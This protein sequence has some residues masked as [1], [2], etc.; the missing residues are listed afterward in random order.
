M[1]LEDY[2]RK[3]VFFVNWHGKKRV[4]HLHTKFSPT[5]RKNTKRHRAETKQA[6]LHLHFAPK[7]IQIR[8]TV[9]ENELFEHT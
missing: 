3:L 5:S 7:I 8:S 2:L 1:T 9:L 6:R 4:F